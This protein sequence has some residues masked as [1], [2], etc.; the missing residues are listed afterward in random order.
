VRRSAGDAEAG[1]RNWTPNH[2]AFL[3]GQL[4]GKDLQAESIA[5][6]T[7]SDATAEPGSSQREAIAT[8][9]GGLEAGGLAS[10]GTLSFPGRAI[11][12][13]EPSGRH[14]LLLGAVAK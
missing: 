9:R 11:I 8:I 3:L 1:T 4:V 10:R 14:T 2:P 5:V 6:A 12:A 7:L 13:S